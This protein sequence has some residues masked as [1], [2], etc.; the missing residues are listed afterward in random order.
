MSALRTQRSANAFAFGNR[1]AVRMAEMPM[2]VNTS[3]NDAVNFVFE[4]RGFRTIARPSGHEP[5]DGAGHGTA[6]IPA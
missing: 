6:H 3:S 1:S 4:S 2:A 5:D